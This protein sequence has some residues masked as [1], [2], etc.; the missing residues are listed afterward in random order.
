MEE[1]N[2][3]GCWKRNEGSAYGLNY[4][5]TLGVI[6]D[7]PRLPLESPPPSSFSRLDHTKRVIIHAPSLHGGCN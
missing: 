3:N 6:F 4:T 1:I 7:P 2:G 5:P